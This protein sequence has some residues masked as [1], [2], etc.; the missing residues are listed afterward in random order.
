MRR[1]LLI[2]VTA[3]VFGGAALGSAASAADGKVFGVC[4]TNSPIVGCLRA[5]PGE[6]P[7]ADGSP[8]VH[9]WARDICCDGAQQWN[10]QYIGSV[11]QQWPFIRS[12][13]GYN[14]TYYGEGVF[15][16]VRGGLCAAEPSYLFG[17]YPVELDRCNGTAGVYWVWTPTGA[18]VNVY[19]TSMLGAP[20]YLTDT[21]RYQAVVTHNT[22]YLDVTTWARVAGR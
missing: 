7:F 13:S 17:T 22:T 1:H 19:Q 11:S 6:V 10:V 4:S 12:G 8:Y 5:V 9:S 20:Q 14:S 16:L 18:L 21:G 3:A 2:A 15:E